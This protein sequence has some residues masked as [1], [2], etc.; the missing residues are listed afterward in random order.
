LV[1]L[2]STIASIK[3]FE[4]FSVCNARRPQCL[5]FARSWVNDVPLSRIGKPRDVGKVAVFLAS[6][7]SSYANRVGLFADGGV[8]QVKGESRTNITASVSVMTSFPHESATQTE[9]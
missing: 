9:N 8:A 4:A 1:I 6:D 5:F 2:T 3:G 7:D